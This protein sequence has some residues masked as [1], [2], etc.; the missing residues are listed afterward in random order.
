MICHSA[1]LISVFFLSVSLAA[2]DF[3]LVKNGKPAAA[4][5][6]PQG[7]SARTYD[8][9]KDFSFRIG[10]CSG[11]ELPVYDTAPGAKILFQEEARTPEDADRYTI[12]FPNSRTMLITGSVCAESSAGTILRCPLSAGIQQ[13]PADASGWIQHGSGSGISGL[14]RHCRSA[15]KNRKNGL[16]QLHAGIPRS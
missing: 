4:L 16:V 15:G 3:Y 2:A 12:E 7:A 8:A 1:L 9:I 6:R 5:I 10:K 13:K 14:R 11:V